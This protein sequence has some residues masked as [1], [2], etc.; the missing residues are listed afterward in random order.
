VRRF[1]TRLVRWLAEALVRLYYPARAVEGGERIPPSGPLVFVL[2]HPNGL[3]DPLVLRVALGRP[4]RF[5][6][7]GT[8]FANPFGRLA[9]DAFDTIPIHRAKEARPGDAARNEASFALWGWN[10]NQEEG[11]PDI[12]SWDPNVENLRYD[13]SNFYGEPLRL[14]LIDDQGVTYC[15]QL[16]DEFGEV[17]FTA[18][19]TT[20]WDNLGTPYDGSTPLVGVQV[21]VPGN[22]RSSVSILR[23]RSLITAS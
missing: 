10:V 14:Q 6:A 17:P 13:V 5:L 2:N 7:K 1:L 23:R 12:A 15:Y 9:M 18:F 20:C 16:P 3:L 21:L 22:T 19:N 8:L 4:A 11:S